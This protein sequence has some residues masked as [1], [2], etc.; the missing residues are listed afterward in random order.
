MMRLERS[1]GGMPHMR[2]GSEVGISDG[3]CE[4]K[5]AGP[6]VGDKVGELIGEVVG[7]TE[8]LARGLTVGDRVGDKVGPKEGAL[9]TLGAT[10]GS[11]DGALETLGA[12]VGSIDGALE[13]LGGTVGSKDGAL[14]TLGATVGG[15][16]PG[17]DGAG[18]GPML[19]TSALARACICSNMEITSSSSSSIC[20]FCAASWSR[21]SLL[22]A[23]MLARMFELSMFTAR[24]RLA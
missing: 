23:S 17:T 10:V 7:A 5:S 19:S 15:L 4:V 16:N 24:I 21:T 12:T 3:S 6:S 22:P 20:S 13:S 8:G 18:V 1:S 14:E 11:K 2:I 9:E